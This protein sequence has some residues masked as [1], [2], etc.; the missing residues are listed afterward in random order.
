LETNAAFENLLGYK[1]QD[2]CQLT[3][4]D[5]V[6]DKCKSID[7]NLQLILMEQPFASEQQY[8][9]LDGQIQG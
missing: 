5:V 3:L 9:R 1:S 8:R 2:I 7:R 6:A 4:Y